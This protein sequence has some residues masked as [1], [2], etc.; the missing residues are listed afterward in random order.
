MNEL[1]FKNS[2]SV[3]I[4]NY[5]YEIIRLWENLKWKMKKKIL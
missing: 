2:I 3:N 5:N 4:F 1:L